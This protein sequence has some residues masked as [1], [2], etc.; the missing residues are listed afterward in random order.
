MADRP[1]IVEIIWH[2]LG[3][4]LGCYGRSDVET[5]F[6]DAF[7]AQGALLEAHFCPAP[8]CSPSRASLKTGLY[9]QSHGML[10]LAHRGWRIRETIPDAPQL[11]AAA[12][13]HTALVGFQHERIEP[14]ELTYQ[15]SQTTFAN[16]LGM[17]E[18][19]TAEEVAELAEGFFAARQG[20]DAPFFLSC[21]FFDVHR[22]Y[23]T[24]YNP[25]VAEML[26]VPLFL[27][28]TPMIRKDM[29]TFYGR[30]KRADAAVGRI[31]HALEAAGLAENTL[32]YFTTDHGPEFP[33]S[34]M[35]MY[36][37]GLKIA[38][39]C[40]WPG[41]I[42]AGRRLVRLSSHVD[43]LPTLLE[44]AGVEAPVT[45]EG[46]SFLRRLK[47]ERGET[48]DA[49]FAQLTWHG[50][51]YD[52]MRCIRTE[53]FKYIRNFQPGWPVQI[54]GP[55]VQ[56]YGEAFIVEHFA[57]PRPDE[58]LYDLLEDPWEMHNLAGQDRFA[59]DQ[60]ELAE[61]L[62][63]WMLTVNDPI[64][65]GPIPFPDPRLVGSGCTWVKAPS[66]APEREAFRWDILRRRD[67]GEKPL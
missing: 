45:C 57:H 62:Q 21:G 1:N 18:E 19:L 2:D 26:D 29:A 15:Q 4:W 37:P 9:P 16:S 13:Y 30:I 7:A 50:G 66:H 51:E 34:K 24:E 31:L 3:D 48:R 43:V 63:T 55:V 28:D 58:E 20:A 27:P 42:P 17:A 49:V 11:L 35:T 54:G 6:L 60:A 38:F 53:R 46:R 36:D 64:L 44:A 23:G 10:G 61:R 52:P 32:V 47:G 33:R 25:A 40:R 12:G 65:R 14:N 41:V 67:F 22:V 56:R 5:P 39:L 8:Q 59:E